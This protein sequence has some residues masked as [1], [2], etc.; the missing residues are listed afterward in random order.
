MG[1]LFSAVLR[2]VLVSCVALP[3]ISSSE[4]EYGAT[5]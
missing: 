3:V 1:A 5:E 4:G 2:K